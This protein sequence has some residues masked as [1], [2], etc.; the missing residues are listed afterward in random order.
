MIF[1]TSSEEKKRQF[2]KVFFDQEFQVCT[3]VKLIENQSIDN[4]L[5]MCKYKFLSVK[6][7]GY[8]DDKLIHIIEDTI[9]EFS[10]DIDYYGK[11]IGTH[12]RNE[13]IRQVIQYLHD[14][15]RVKLISNLFYYKDYD[16]G[17]FK[18]EQEGYFFL[19]I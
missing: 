1:Y 3:E 4:C 10:D 8:W 19:M 6:N 11:R 16:Y 2:E 15:G 17:F 12:I 18:A 9:V 5:M 7:S 14:K 13:G